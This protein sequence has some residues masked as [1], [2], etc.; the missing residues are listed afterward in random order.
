MGGV[1]AFSF[2]PPGTRQAAP[3]RLGPVV[4]WP[5]QAPLWVRKP[6]LAMVR[7]FAVG[8]GSLDQRCGIDCITPSSGK[9]GAGRSFVT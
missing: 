2:Y 8:N 7:I 5:T 4:P 9:S 3:G 1:S 6:L